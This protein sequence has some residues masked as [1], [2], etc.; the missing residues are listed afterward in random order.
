M[1]ANPQGSI[2]EDLKKAWLKAGNTAKAQP[3]L[4]LCILPNTGVPL[5]AEIKHV[6]D[7]VLGVPSQRIQRKHTV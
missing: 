6:T 7:T 2:E 4:L 3:Q 1:H 5:Y